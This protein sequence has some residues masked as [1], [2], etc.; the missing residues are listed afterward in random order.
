MVQVGGVV[1]GEHQVKATSEWHLWMVLETAISASFAASYDEGC[2]VERARSSALIL[3]R[4]Q[5]DLSPHDCPP[6]PV[7]AAPFLRRPRF[8]AGPEIAEGPSLDTH[9]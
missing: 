1:L 6:L 4:L 8:D 5:L 3:S 2:R 7:A 9:R